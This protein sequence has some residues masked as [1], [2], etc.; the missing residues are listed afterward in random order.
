MKRLPLLAA[1]CIALF[2]AGLAGLP[3]LAGFWGQAFVFVAAWEAR[4]DPDTAGA[5]LP[6]A[7]FL[8]ALMAAVA[9]RELRDGEVVFVGIGLP[10]LACNL[11]RRTHAPR[12]TLIYESGAV[13]AVPERLPVSIGDPALVTGSLMVC[14]MADVFQLFLQNGRIEVGFLG[15]VQVDR[16]ANINTTVIGAY[17]RPKVRLPGSGGAAEIAIH[18]QRILVIAK[19]SRRAFPERVDFRTS[20]GQ[21]V[22]KVITD[23]GVLVRDAESGELLLAALYPGIETADVQDVQ[24]AAP[25]APPVRFAR[26]G[27]GLSFEPPAEWGWKL[28]GSPRSLPLDPSAQAAHGARRADACRRHLRGEP[29]QQRAP[30]RLALE[31][32]EHRG[33]RLEVRPVSG[34]DP[35]GLTHTL[36]EPEAD[37]GLDA[38]DHDRHARCDPADGPCR[39]RQQRSPGHGR[40]A[41]TQ[42]GSGAPSRCR[43]AGQRIGANAHRHGLAE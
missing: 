2:F 34:H 18:A 8:V 27:G 19:L 25:G 41:Q 12:L 36:A 16:Y 13:G 31:P 17:D 23:K 14:G 1:S 21:R 10:N 43:Q 3:P 24:I 26:K 35:V 30:Q 7:G 6:H 37:A 28:L 15:G 4:L 5:A 29:R 9:S 22:A 20:P 39:H 38:Q 33:Q 42:P 40:R 11:A 32:L